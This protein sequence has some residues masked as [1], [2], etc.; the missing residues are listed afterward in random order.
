MKEYIED[1]KFMI[2]KYEENFVA[3]YYCFSKEQLNDYIAEYLK[4]NIINNDLDF[5]VFFKMH[6]K[7]T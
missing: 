6:Y 3:P 5:F 1:L 4:N 7:K 2:E